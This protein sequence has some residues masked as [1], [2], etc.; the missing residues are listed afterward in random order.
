MTDAE[1]LA[2]KDAAEKWCKNATDHCTKHGGKPWKYALIS[3]D[4]IAEN[5]TIHGLLS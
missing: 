3:H 5:M 2:K 1:V 4:R